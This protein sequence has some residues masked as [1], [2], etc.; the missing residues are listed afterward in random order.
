MI[1]S[2]ITW[3]ST[4][5]HMAWSRLYNAFIAPDSA[6]DAGTIIVLTNLGTMRSIG[7]VNAVRDRA[8]RTDDSHMLLTTNVG[9]VASPSW[10]NIADEVGEGETQTYTHSVTVSGIKDG[11]IAEIEGQTQQLIVDGTMVSYRDTNS[12]ALAGALRYEIATPTTSSK[13]ITTVVS[14][15]HDWG[16]NILVSSAGS[17]MVNW[18]YSQGIPD[19]VAAMVASGFETAMRVIAGLLVEQNARVAA[20]EAKIRSGFDRLVVEDLVVNN[21]L[22]VE[23]EDDHYEG[24]GAP[25]IISSRKGRRYLDTTSK[26]WY[27]ATGNTAASQWKQ[28]TN[29]S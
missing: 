1:V 11:G 13:S 4:C 15:L 19:S 26:L 8:D 25:A 6:L 9:L 3:A 18:Q 21:K 24:A 17:A 2:G 27:T 14:A 5:A 16:I 29:A 12:T 23:G 20:V 7:G 28:D 10:S 22:S